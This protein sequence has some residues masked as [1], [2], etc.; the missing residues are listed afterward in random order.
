MNPMMAALE[1]SRASNPAPAGGGPGAPGGAPVAPPQ[2]ADPIMKLSATLD[3]V[4]AKIDKLTQAI[5]GQY[6]GKTEPENDGNE[7]QEK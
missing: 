2:G 5:S 7:A 4:N 3:E 6:Q 1:Q